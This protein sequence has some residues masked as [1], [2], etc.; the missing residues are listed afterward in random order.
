VKD[1][2]TE[3]CEL[4]LW[5]DDVHVFNTTMINNS[6]ETGTPYPPWNQ[7]F[8]IPPGASSVS[9][10]HTTEE[11]RSGEKSFR[12]RFAYSGV[13]PPGEWGELYQYVTFR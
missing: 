7:T 11:R 1:Y 13:Y 3:I 4:F 10:A 8:F 5:V 2:R 6:M 9:T 12:I